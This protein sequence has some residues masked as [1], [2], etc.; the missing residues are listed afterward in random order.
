M[1]WVRTVDLL[2]LAIWLTLDTLVLCRR[3]TRAAVRADRFSALVIIAANA[4]GICAAVSLA[5]SGIGALGHFT[6]PAQA[7]GFALFLTGVVVRAAAIA[8]LGR[9][10]TAAVAIQD[11]HRVVCTGLYRRIRHPSYLGACLV[12]LGFGLAL[13]NGLSAAAVLLTAL[14][15]YVYRIRVEE[16]MLLELLGAE[17]RAYCGRTHRFLPGIY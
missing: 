5:E 16:K 13:G 11:G 8:Q 10:H 17:Y 6:M 3:R 15:G 9:F 2:G 4:F 7:L 12:F 1:A 14:V